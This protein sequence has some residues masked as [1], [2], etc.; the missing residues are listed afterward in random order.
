LPT[1]T[2]RRGPAAAG[3]SVRGHPAIHGE[4]AAGHVG[5]GIRRRKHNAAS[6]LIGRSGAL[7][8]QAGEQTRLR[9]VAGG[10]AVEPRSSG[11]NG[12]M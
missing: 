8:R 6:D 1:R 2:D 10:K 7:Q 4:N 12:S 11:A 3:R 5:R 9:F